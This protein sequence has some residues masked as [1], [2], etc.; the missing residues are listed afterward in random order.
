VRVASQPFTESYLLA[1]LEA[2]LIDATGEASAS[3]K[4]GMSSPQMIVAALQSGEVD[5]SVGYTGFLARLYLKDR[6]S[7]TLPEVQAAMATRQITLSAPLG[8]NNTYALAVR[9]STARELHLQKISDLARHPGLRGAFT[10]G[11]DNHEDGIYKLQEVYGFTLASIRP[12]EHALAYAALVHHEIDLTDA[13]TTDGTLAQYELTLLQDDRAFFPAYDGVLLVRARFPQQY[14]RTWAALQKLQGR[15]SDQKMAQLNARVDNKQSTI[16]E[17]ATAFLREQHLLTDQALARQAATRPA[18]A[19]PEVSL[20][21]STVEH[22][23]LVVSA[24]LLSCL[25]GLPLGILSYYRRRFGRGLLAL[26]GLLQTIPSLALLCFL[27]PWLGIGEL[28]TIFALFLYGLLPIAQSTAAGLLAIDARLVET[29]RILGLSRLQRLRLVELPLASINI[30]A[31]IK[32]CAVINVGTATIATLIGAGGYGR[33]ITS[34]LALNDVALI[35]KGAVPAALMAV[36]FSAV[37][38]LL[39][40]LFIPQSLRA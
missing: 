35:L 15:L 21:R 34:G 6:K 27:I 19:G 23:T 16:A 3:R 32:T 28:P 8:F 18:E 20:L 10:P 2:Q 7:A 33:Y 9:S 13:Y 29:A 14:P 38:E 1:E 22:L 5:V 39:D 11:F 25:C 24:L 12:M 40:R 4:F 37:F 36:A 17:T 26:T 30:L 31:G